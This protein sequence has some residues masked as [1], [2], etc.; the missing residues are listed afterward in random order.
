LANRLTDKSVEQAKGETARREIPDALLPGLYL[1]IQPTGAK[2]WAIRYRLD[3]RP[4]K[5]TL[6]PFP[7]IKLG[8]ARRLAGA[9]LR[10]VAEG[11]DPAG[12]RRETRRRQEAG[13]VDVDL[14]EAVYA[15][16][17]DRHVRPNLRPSTA[18]ELEALFAREI[19]PKWRK[20][21][22][23]EV[24][25]QDVLDLV[26]GVLDRGVPVTANKVFAQLR[27]F[28]NWAVGRGL[29]AASP[30]VGIRKPAAET[31]RERALTD[32]EVRWLWMACDKIGWPFGPITR[33]L[34]L[35]GARREEVRAM[36]EREIDIEARVWTIPAARTKN[37]RPHEIHLTNAAADVIAKTRRVKSPAGYLFTVT[38]NTPPSGFSRAK[39]NLD[40]AML[41]LAREEAGKR[42]D[43]PGAVEIAPW[44]LH[45]L[46]RTIAS[47][48]ARLGIALPVV[49]RCLNH[50][51]GSFAGIVGVYQ[52]H[53]FT[54]EKRDAF[55]AWA[56][57]IGTVV[58]DEPGEFVPFL[59]RA[60]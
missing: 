6:G 7:K 1:V 52:K 31:S 32:A 16:Y 41:D 36:T 30:C 2:S 49:E 27:T 18:R 8:D 3:G 50:V 9:A 55:E 12:D 19:L 56:R 13:L 47:G 24:S 26:D 33:L 4:A 54:D 43:D 21:R 17:L 48:M 23:A 51:S 15:K 11:G 44:V 28:F 57:H 59:A 40:L 14:I 60:P 34:I 37:G 25:R 42:G 58:K 46:R 29:I 10:T 45:D 38:G 35:T 5:H 22:L 20:R 53:A 39:R